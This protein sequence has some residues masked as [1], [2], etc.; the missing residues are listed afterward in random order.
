M[1]LNASKKTHQDEM[2]RYPCKDLVHGHISAVGTGTPGEEACITYAS[3]KDQVPVNQWTMIA[4]TYDS[5]Y[6]RIFVD[7]K[8]SHDEK[9][10]PFKYDK[11]IFNGGDDGAGFTVGANS[12]HGIITNQ[13]IGLI[14]G[15]AV[16]NIA[17]TESE[18][19]VIFRDGV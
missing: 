15:L 1:F 8:L 11:G 3:S 2:K 17:L 18:L 9:T 13:F 14:D 7:G 12:A 6:I 19:Q 10:N 5:E 4:M 16:Y